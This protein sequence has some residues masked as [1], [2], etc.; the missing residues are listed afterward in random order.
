MQKG[1]IAAV[2]N[3]RD[4]ET[5]LSSG[6]S[7]VFL[8]KSNIL[9]LDRMCEKA[10]AAGKP[11]YAH[12]DMADGIGKDK[13]GVAYLARRG[14]GVISTK[15]N[16]IAC[17]REI[18]IPTVQRFF[19]ID[20]Q[21]IASAAEAVRSARPAAAE[22]MPGLAGVVESLRNLAVPVI[23]GGLIGDINRLEAAFAAGASA[24]ST[25]ET[26]LWNYRRSGQ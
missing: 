24:V 25:S 4:F 17:A 1:V 7:A 5:A 8:L 11:L 26:S 20:S 21:S 12:L 23:A 13:A 10:Q 19:I 6:A 3:D 2:R 22:L 14:A 15:S 9:T 16:L 18:G